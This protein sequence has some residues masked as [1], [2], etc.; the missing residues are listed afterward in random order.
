MDEAPKRPVRRSDLG[1]H[2]HWPFYFGLWS[3]VILLVV[4]W[5]WRLVTGTEIDWPATFG[6]LAS[7]LT[8]IAIV[9]GG[10]WTLFVLQRRRARESRAELK[11]AISLWMMGDRRMLR[12]AVTLRNCGEVAINPGVSFTSVQKP[13]AGLPAAEELVE[14]S[15]QEFERI[16]HPWASHLVVVEPGETET[17]YHDVAVPAECRYIQVATVVECEDGGD[18]GLNWDEVTLIDVDQLAKGP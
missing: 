4:V 1:R 5:G 2:L 11:H 3:L 16:D 10:W 15:W 12:L 6:S 14:K 17:Y 9:L 18:D 13:P 8:S 7:G